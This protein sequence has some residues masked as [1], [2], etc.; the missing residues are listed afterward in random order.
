[1]GRYWVG[2]GI[3]RTETGNAIVPGQDLDPAYAA[4]SAP[5]GQ[6]SITVVTTSY[7]RLYDVLR[8]PEWRQTIGEGI[9]LFRE[10]LQP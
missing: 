10:A 8:N 1:V 9:R 2:P 5:Y 4:V 3:L 7:A 6:G